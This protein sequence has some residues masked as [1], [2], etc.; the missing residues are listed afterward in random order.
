VPD[1]LISFYSH[2][3]WRLIAQSLILHRVMLQCENVLGSVHG[4]SS[5][6]PGAPSPSSCTVNEPWR[7]NTGAR[8]FCATQSDGFSPALAKIA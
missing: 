5:L 8:C 4:C 6:F 1:S 3:N 7:P 2:N